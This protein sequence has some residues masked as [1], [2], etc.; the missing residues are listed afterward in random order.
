MHV[1]MLGQQITQRMSCSWSS[2]RGG[3]PQLATKQ[4]ETGDAHNK[5]HHQLSLGLRA[6]PLS[7]CVVHSL[8]LILI[9][10]LCGV[11]KI[12]ARCKKDLWRF[13]SGI[14]GSAGAGEQ[15]RQ[16]GREIFRARLQGA[17]AAC[18]SPSNNL[19]LLCFC[20]SRSFYRTSPRTMLN[21]ARQ[22]H[23]NEKQA[24]LAVS[25]CQCRD[26]I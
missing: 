18:A 17:A 4:L 24:R 21:C 25:P 20:C 16:W 23:T 13:V 7:H 19:L 10:L 15:G 6:P 2:P 9:L 5:S 3:G 26:L 1:R 12:T 11:N 22:R 14:K 8:L